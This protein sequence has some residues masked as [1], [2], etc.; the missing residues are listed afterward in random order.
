MHFT[1]RL[2][3]PGRFQDSQHSTDDALLDGQHFVVDEKF[4]PAERVQ[5][6]WRSAE[7]IAL[8]KDRSDGDGTS[9]EDYVSRR[10]RWAEQK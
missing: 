1:V 9:H 3:S 7:M 4:G 8:D 10:V 2:P 6:S 5:V